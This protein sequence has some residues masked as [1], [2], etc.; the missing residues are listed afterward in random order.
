MPSIVEINPRI[1]AV[2]GWRHRQAVAQL[3]TG[4]SWLAVE[5]GRHQGSERVDGVCQRCSSSAID[6]IDHKIVDCSAFEICWWNLP[7]SFAYDTMFLIDSTVRDLPEPAASLPSAK[8]LALFDRAFRLE[9]RVYNYFLIQAV[10]LASV[11][12]SCS[13]FG[14]MRRSMMAFTTLR[15]LSFMALVDP[16][17]PYTGA[18]VHLCV[19]AG[20]APASLSQTTSQIHHQEALSVTS[21]KHIFRSKNRAGL[22]NGPQRRN[23]PPVIHVPMAA[24]S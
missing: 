15:K 20:S 19:I 8:K 18:C 3:R 10:H 11:L 24:P 13:V 4:L 12:A 9:L 23:T 5:T 1:F 16:G 14:Y 21:Y 22:Q 17:A 2:A 7:N 6:G